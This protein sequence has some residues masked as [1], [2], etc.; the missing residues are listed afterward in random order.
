MSH[1][2][3]TERPLSAFDGGTVCVS[4]S[5]TTIANLKAYIAL[6]GLDWEVLPF[7]LSQGRNDAFFSRRC[8]LLTADRLVLA[9]LR[10]T[11]VDDPGNYVLHEEIISKEPFVAYVSC[12][13]MLWGNF[14]RWAIMVTI[15]AEEK[16]I[17]SG[18]YTDHLD[19]A[20]PAVRRLL[21]VD[22]LPAS[23]T[24]GLA[25]D[26]PR[27]VIAGAGNY[28][29]IFERYLGEQSQLGIDRGLNRLWRDSGLMFSPP[30]R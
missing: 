29:E 23:D 14:V 2:D 25:A 21:G 1:R 4:H 7:E 17:T 22:P 19:S 5:T 20:D 26:W 16:G 6:N 8:D 24:A 30:L 10:A 27:R 15:I 13:D 18:N 3:A 9:T 11:D 12:V 28:G